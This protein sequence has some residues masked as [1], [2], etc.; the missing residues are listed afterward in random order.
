MSES[1]KMDCHA[2]AKARG[3]AWA[4]HYLIKEPLVRDFS[5]SSSSSRTWPNLRHKVST[6]LLPKIKRPAAVTIPIGRLKTD[7]L[8]HIRAKG[9]RTRKDDEYE[10]EA[11]RGLD[12]QPKSLV[13]I[14]G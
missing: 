2:G 11:P 5:S 12:K 10:N 3:S 4:L 1:G 13:E 9:S 6:D 8:L 14:G 7:I